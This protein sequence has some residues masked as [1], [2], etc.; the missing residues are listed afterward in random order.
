MSP[1]LLEQQVRE[2]ALQVEALSTGRSGRLAAITVGAPSSALEME[3]EFRLRQRL[4]DIA[5][6][7]TIHVDEGMD[8]ALE[9][10]SLE[11][12]WCP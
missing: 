2:I 11:F 10:L 6:S 9:L 3:L 1:L 5:R 4:G 7:I 12:T 8:G